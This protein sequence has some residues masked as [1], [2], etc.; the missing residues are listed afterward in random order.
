MSGTNQPIEALARGLRVLEALS[1]SSGSMGNGQ[2]ARVTN[3]PPSTVSRLT[4]SLVR[5]GY[6]QMD[7]TSGAYSLTAKNLRLGYP[8]L[9]NISILGRSQRVLNTLSADTGLTS[10]LAIR[11]GLH[12]ATVATVRGRHP[13]SVSL[14]VGGRLPLAV[15][16]SGVALISG[17]EEPHKSRL[18]KEICAGLQARG[19][20]VGDFESQL[21][22]C[23]ETTVA[24]SRG[25]WHDDIGG[26]AT[27]IRSGGQLFAL[28]V[29]FK[30]NGT[31]AE[32][33]KLPVQALRRAA[34]ELAD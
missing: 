3:L 19:R 8:V 4:D 14:A 1:R 28:G 30:S 25:A 7:S 10:A 20:S 15:S 17:L 27:P 12:V 11:D 5:L 13:H 16:A 31:S 6:L 21:K 2:I 33:G 9:A 23:E 18:V 29:V 22:A 24:V 34:E 26:M 32:L